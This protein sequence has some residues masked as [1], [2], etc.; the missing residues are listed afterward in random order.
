MQPKIKP[1]SI[2]F[3]IGFTKPFIMNKSQFYKSISSKLIVGAGKYF[4]RKLRFLMPQ[5]Y[6]KFKAV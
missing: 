3:D 5:A 2:L 6:F 4:L 1:I